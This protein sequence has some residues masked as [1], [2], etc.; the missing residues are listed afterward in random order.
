[1]L[2]LHNI[3]LTTMVR[4]RELP[5]F[6]IS[7]TTRL[8]VQGFAVD[9]LVLIKSNPVDAM[10]PEQS[11]FVV[12]RIGVVTKVWGEWS[13][14]QTLSCSV[15]LL[16]VDHQAGRLAA[17]QDVVPKIYARKLIGIERLDL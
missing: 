2:C 5:I 14:S 13:I 15:T 4:Q 16:Q 11:Q 1:M 10:S 8:C 17:T 7:Y 3:L 12:N 9:D 6:F